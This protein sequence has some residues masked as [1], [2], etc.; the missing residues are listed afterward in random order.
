MIPVVVTGASGRM[1][2]QLVRQV[3]A[4]EGLTLAAATE[5]P[6][7]AEGADVGVLAG[8]G[9]IGVPIRGR[10]EDAL[11][12]TKG[13]VVVDFTSHEASA[14]HA[15]IC[16]E[17]GAALVIGSTGFT[18]E[19]KARVAAAAQRVPIVLSPNMSVGVNVLFALVREAAAILGDGFDVE[20]VEMHHRKKKDAP[21]GTA[22]RLAEVAASALGRDLAKDLVFARHGMVGERTGKEIGVQTLR[23]GDVVGDHTVYFVADGERIELT[24]RATSREQFASGAVRAI[25]WIAGRPAGLYDMAAVLGLGGA[26]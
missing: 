23:G 7:H 21:S 13:L 16:A 15:E 10:L 6:G 2:S 19:T 17:R 24:H 11:G 5:R 9:P 18:A 3:R 14:R 20:I 4:A 25:R 1:G 26:R 22:V 12:A 8:L